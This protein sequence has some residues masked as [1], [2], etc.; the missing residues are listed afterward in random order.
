MIHAIT[1]QLEGE[2][3]PQNADAFLT[4]GL[5]VEGCLPRARALELHMSEGIVRRGR[6]VDGRDDHFDV[7]GLVEH[8]R[9]KSRQLAR[10]EED[11]LAICLGHPLHGVIV[12]HE[13]RRHLHGTVRLDFHGARRAERALGDLLVFAHNRTELCERNRQQQIA[14]AETCHGVISL[15]EQI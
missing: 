12:M 10:L 13:A 3:L 7:D 9:G 2:F 8:L 14:D 11:C 6:L 1:E 5:N 4:G 15:L